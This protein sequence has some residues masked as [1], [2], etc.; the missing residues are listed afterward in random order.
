M[1]RD[2]PGT[3]GHAWRPPDYEVDEQG[4]KVGAEPPEL[5]NW[6]RWGED[7]QRGTTNLITPEVVQ[8]ASPDLSVTDRRC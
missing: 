6:G 2:G 3:Y 5:H 1:G 7:D 4:K 8:S